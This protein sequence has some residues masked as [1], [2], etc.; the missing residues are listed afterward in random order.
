MKRKVNSLLPRLFLLL[1][2]I[3]GVKGFSQVMQ[4]ADGTPLKASYCLQDSNFELMGIPGGGTFSGCGIYEQNGQ[5][6][7]N[8]VVA[9]SGTT[10]YPFQCMIQYTV[11]G[12]TASQ[13]IV[14]AKPVAVHPPLKDSV[15]CNGN[16]LLQATMLYA[17]AY[18]YQWSPASPLDRSDT[19]LTAGSIQ[20]SQT[21]V[22]TATD[23]ASGCI[24]TDT[25]TIVRDTPPVVKVSRDTTILPRTSVQ[26]EAS[27]AFTYKWS[28]AAWLDHPGIA[29]PLA[30]PR[31]DITYTVTGRSEH[32]CYGSAEVNIRI[33]DNIFIPNVFSPNGDGINDVFRIV[34]YGFDELLE[35]RV[36]DRWGKVVFHTSGGLNGWDG[37]YNGKPA[38]SGTYYYNIQIAR[39][40]NLTTVMKG[41]VALIR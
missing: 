16:I 6:Y 13:P 17:G 21:F 41:D 26:L 39:K 30:T 3:P 20:S 36:F 38:E 32:G 5:W 33:N 11:N 35:F 40:N 14:I 15:S 9:T 27:G 34:N 1:L 37:T 8:P 31:E 4:N 7:F 2:L 23:M 28:P 24:G 12:A 19:S 25:I 29:A 22:L 18:N 10:V